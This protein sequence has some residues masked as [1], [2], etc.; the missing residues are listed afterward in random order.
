MDP[1][2]LSHALHEAG[3]Y[4]STGSFE[5]F[6]IIILEGF[7]HFTLELTGDFIDHHG[8]RRMGKCKILGIAK[9]VRPFEENQK[10]ILR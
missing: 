5:K 10:I 7:R 4:A 8:F 1:G 2:V 9:A 6:Q 3:Q